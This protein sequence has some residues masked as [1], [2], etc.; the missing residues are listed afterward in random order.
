MCCPVYKVGVMANSMCQLKSTQT[1]AQ[2]L[3]WMWVW[4]RFCIR[5]TFESVTEQ[6][7][8]WSPRWVGLIQFPGGLNR[9]N[10]WHRWQPLL[11][12]YEGTG[13]SWSSSGTGTPV[14]HPGTAGPGIGLY[15]WFSYRLIVGFFS[16]HNHV[17][18]SCTINLFCYVHW[19]V[20]SLGSVSLDSYGKFP[21]NPCHL[22]VN[23]Q[24]G[25]SSRISEVGNTH[26]SWAC[27]WRL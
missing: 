27:P 9:I 20:Y 12:D 5:L 17:I 18:Q 8:S 13:L 15:H 22:D 26:L 3:L 19:H 7:K 6:S 14:L 10:R 25:P 21:N 1:F 4:G 16:P 24:N 2:T 11:P 23:Q